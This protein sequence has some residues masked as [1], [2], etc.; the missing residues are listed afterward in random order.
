MSTTKVRDKFTA[1]FNRVTKKGERVILKRGGKEIAA[2][3]PIEDLEMLERYEDEVDL[4]TARKA[5]KEKGG[6]T[7]EE[8]CKSRGIKL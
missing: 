7:L 5:K 6:I 2:L 8:Y 4:K 3:V 1:A